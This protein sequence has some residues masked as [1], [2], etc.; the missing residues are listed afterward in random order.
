MSWQRKQRVQ[1]EHPTPVR[2][3]GAAPR[4]VNCLGLPAVVR[5]HRE[6]VDKARRG[7][8]CGYCGY[9]PRVEIVEDESVREVV[10]PG[11]FGDGA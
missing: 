9:A 6:E 8:V 5:V 7:P 2:A 11:A 10:P 4:C 3:P 1:R